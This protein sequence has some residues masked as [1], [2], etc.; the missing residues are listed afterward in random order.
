[1]AESNHITRRHSDTIVDS[2]IHT[3]VKFRDKLYQLQCYNGT[4][5]CATV[6]PIYR[7]CQIKY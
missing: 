1:M 6:V 3:M 2:L 7:Y 4:D 5:S